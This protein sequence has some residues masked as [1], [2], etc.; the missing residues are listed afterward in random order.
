M[1][2]LCML[3]GYMPLVPKFAKNFNSSSW[4]LLGPPI[5]ETAWLA[6]FCKSCGLIAPHA[7][8]NNRKNANPVSVIE[9]GVVVFLRLDEEPP[10]SLI[11]SVSSVALF[12]LCCK[13]PFLFFEVS[14]MVETRFTHKAIEKRE[15]EKLL[16]C[17]CRQSWIVLVSLLEL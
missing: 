2:W 10:A 16:Q 4:H 13:P 11:S 9:P 7:N 15:P 12:F 5:S 1:S 14:M 6:I 3:F 8:C 17:Q